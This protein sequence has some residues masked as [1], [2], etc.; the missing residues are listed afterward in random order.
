VKKNHRAVGALLIAAT[1]FSSCSIFTQSG[2]QQRAYER[3][4]RKSSLAR[5]QQQK[6]LRPIKTSVPVIEPS[7]PTE[8]SG[9]EAMSVGGL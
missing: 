8:S 3:Y 4:V 6:R 1:L 2:R 5:V 9:P 7:E